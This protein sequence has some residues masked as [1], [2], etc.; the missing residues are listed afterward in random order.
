MSSRNKI[1]WSRQ[2][3]IQIN[4]SLEKIKDNI[5]SATAIDEN[6]SDPLYIHSESTESQIYSAAFYENKFL[7]CGMAGQVQGLAV[8]N[9]KISKKAWNIPIPLT[10]DTRD[11]DEVNS[12]W[13][14]KE[15]GLLFAGCGDNNIYCA[16]LENGKIV[17]TLKGHQDYIHSVHG[18]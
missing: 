1:S 16:S 4:F 3:L 18:L 5:E 7:I 8:K 13:V 9:G 15:N 17:R 6:P 10:P 14:D 11:M 12:L 2:I